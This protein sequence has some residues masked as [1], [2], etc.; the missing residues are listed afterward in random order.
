MY[1]RRSG[2][3]AAPL[4]RRTGASLALEALQ[5]PVQRRC[6]AAAA[7]LQRQKAWPGSKKAK[8]LPF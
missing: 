3:A 1:W 5:A 4:R 7:P 6:G 2:A 8:K